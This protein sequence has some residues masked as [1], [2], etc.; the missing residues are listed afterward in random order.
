MTYDK[1]SIGPVIMFIFWSIIMAIVCIV[2]ISNVFA[3]EYTFSYNDT[4][5]YYDNLGSSVTY[6]NSSWNESLQAYVSDNITTTANS[7][8]AGVSI[9]A[10]VPILQNHTYTLTLAFPDLSNI[11][12]SSKNHIAL[13][14]SALGAANNYASGN[15]YAEMQYST[16]QSNKILQFVFKATGNASYIFIPW[17]TTYTTTQSYFLNKIIIEDLGSEGVSQDQI[18][19]SLGNQTTQ[20]QNSLNNTENNIKNEIKNTEDNIKDSI[21]DGFESC[22]DSYNLIK[23]SYDSK[24]Y[25]GLTLTFVDNGFNLTGTGINM[26]G[27]F[28][29]SK[30]TLSS[31][32]YTINGVDGSSGSTYQLVI[33]DNTNEKTLSYVQKNSVS[34][35]IT[36]TINVELRFYPYQTTYDN[37]LFQYQLEKGTT[38]H[39]YEKYGEKICSNRID[40]T[41]KKLDEQNETSK[42]IFGKIKDL[43]NWLTNK[44]DADVSSAGNV[45]GWL[46]AGP[47]DSLINLPLTF[48]TNVNTSLSKTCSPLDVNL[49]YV[50]KVVQIPCLNTIFNQITGLNNFWTWV[51]TI[52]SVVILFRYL[53]A[54][55]DYFDK[56]TTLQA[57]F[58]SDWGGV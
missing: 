57:N 1:K 24:T 5:T 16:N 8:G 23:P 19:I 55:Y 46:P 32:T 35:T 48:L 58:I 42:G 4:Q 45:A 26:Y 53:L 37:K 52:S 49:P 30:I 7:Y 12:L 38:V 34:F 20:I 44:D 39:D 22:R 41:N 54:L 47:V 6:V 27:Y 18:N 13:S 11:S 17:T 15:Y 31:G 9:N 14:I 2:G 29:I 51:G 33:Y 21:K 28:T 50:N 43:F 10:P 56:L 40:D 3:A 36:D 25:N